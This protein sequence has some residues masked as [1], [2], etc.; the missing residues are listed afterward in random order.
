M[1]FSASEGWVMTS[2]TTLLCIF[3]HVL[4]SEEKTEKTDKKYSNVSDSFPQF[5]CLCSFILNHKIHTFQVTAIYWREF[6]NEN[7]QTEY[8]IFDRRNIMTFTCESLYYINLRFSPRFKVLESNSNMLQ[9]IFSATY[10]L[11]RHIFVNIV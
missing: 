5:V 11:W 7:I 1:C 9:N 10:T 6:I 8:T 4:T 3:C 2:W